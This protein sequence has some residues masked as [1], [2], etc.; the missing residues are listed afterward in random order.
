MTVWPNRR[1][2]RELLRR[3]KYKPTICVLA[4]LITEQ[5]PADG[6]LQR[7]HAVD[8]LFPQQFLR[9]YLMGDAPDGEPMNME[10]VDEQH[11]FI[12]F[13]SFDKRQLCFVF[14]LI[15]AVGRTYIHSAYRLFA[16]RVSPKMTE[17]L[18]LPG[19]Q[20]IWDVHGAV[21]E[22]CE[23]NG[24]PGIARVAERIE[25]QLYRRSSLILCVS[26]AMKQHLRE[27]YGDTPAKKTVLPI[28]ADVEIPELKPR[29][30]EPVILYS[31]GLQNW[32]NI[33]EMQDLM[34]ATM[35]KYNYRVLVPNPEGFLRLWGERPDPVMEITSRAPKEMAAEYDRCH[36]GLALRDDIAV[37]RV[38]CPTKIIEYLEHGV[39]PI[40]K[41][42][43][44]GDFVSLGMQYISADRLSAGTL[45]DEAER[46]AMAEHNFTVLEKLHTQREMGTDV[47]TAHLQKE[48]G[49][50]PGVFA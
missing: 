41:S 15:E 26:E 32:Q 17:M 49:T 36:Y 30:E 35:E 19:V 16:G 42:T 4:P 48:T 8:G 6:Y 25:E 24:D 23:L 3:T 46:R 13:D 33:P 14:R 44:I 38:A 43:C 18:Q 9:I 34:A 11:F 47:F 5:N 2:Q 20:H 50:D 1:Q 40:L 39:V 28:F 27:K 22:E 7:I 29:P 45:P 21:P 12:R 10:E 37:N 31:G